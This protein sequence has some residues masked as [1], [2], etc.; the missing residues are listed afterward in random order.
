MGSFD[1]YVIVYLFNVSLQAYS[2]HCKAQT[3]NTEYKNIVEYSP[4]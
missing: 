3:I 2:A 4:K 1:V